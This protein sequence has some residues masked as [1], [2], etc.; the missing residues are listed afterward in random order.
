MIVEGRNVS[1]IGNYNVC[2]RSDVGVRDLKVI[3]ILW[4]VAG[5]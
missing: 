5:L 4:I 2:I 1:E 3:G